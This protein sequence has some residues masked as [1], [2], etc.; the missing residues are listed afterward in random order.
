MMKKLALSVAFLSV[1]SMGTA[2]IFSAKAA[3]ASDEAIVGSWCVTYHSGTATVPLVFNF[4]ADGNMSVLNGNTWTL[5]GPS[6]FTRTSGQGQVDKV[7][8]NEWMGSYQYFDHNIDGSF[9]RRFI[10]HTPVVYDRD[11]DT[12]SDGGNPQNPIVLKFVNLAGVDITPSLPPQSYK[13][14][15]VDKDNPFLC[16]VPNPAF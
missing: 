16:D 5:P 7:G 11:T 3:A 9:L 12:I 6:A 1:I 8:A 13:A 4:N 15:R 2:A 14:S 10:V